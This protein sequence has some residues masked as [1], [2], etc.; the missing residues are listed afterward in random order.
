MSMGARAAA[1]DGRH[2][3]RA[4]ARREVEV[5]RVDRELGDM[6]GAHRSVTANTPASVAAPAAVHAT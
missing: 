2:P 4:A 3:P 1:G 5:L 6:L